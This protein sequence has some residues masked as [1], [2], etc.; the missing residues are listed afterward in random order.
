MNRVILSGRIVRDPEIRSSQSGSQ[1]TVARYSLAVQRRKKQDGQNTA[2]FVNCIAFGQTADFAGKY[3]KQGMKVLIQGR[4]QSGS[5]TSRTTDQKVYTTEVVVEEQE[6]A[7]GR[8]DD[9]SA[10][11]AAETRDNGS[12]AGR[13]NDEMG[14][15]S[16]EFSDYL[17]A[18]E[19]LMDILPWK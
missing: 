8:R 2:D 6:F 11:Q 17:D 7:E 16:G 12:E 9:S 4:I 1:V 3:L 15:L 18:D 13:I 14:A 19:D 5:Y 10:S